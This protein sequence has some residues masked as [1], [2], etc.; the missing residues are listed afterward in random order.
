MARSASLRTIEPVANAQPVANC[1]KRSAFAVFGALSVA[2]MD[3]SDIVI[4][5]RKS[6]ANRRVH[7][8]TEKDDGAGLGRMWG[9]S[10]HSA[11]MINARVEVVRKWD[12]KAEEFLANVPEESTLLDCGIR[13]PEFHS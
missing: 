10:R 8:S 3:G 2:H 13:L 5:H 7:A 11:T 12:H 6:S 1:H 4:A 9:R